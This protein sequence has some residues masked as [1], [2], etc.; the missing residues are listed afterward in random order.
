MTIYDIFSKSVEEGIAAD[1]RPMDE[2][3][4]YFWSEKISNGD[5]REL[6]NPYP[7]SGMIFVKETNKEVQRVLVGIDIGEGEI[8]GARMFEDETGKKIDLVISHHPHGKPLRNFHFILKTQLGNLKHCGVSV[9]GLER[10]YDRRMK[11]MEYDIMAVNFHRIRDT[12][13]I[14]G[15]DGISIHTPVDNLA[16]R[17]IQKTVSESGAKTLEDCLSALFCVPEYR[18]CR[19]ED[20]MS[21]TI[22]SGHKRGLLGRFLL[23]EFTGGEEGP[24]AVYRAM[25]RSGID[26]L[27]VMHMSYEALQEAKKNKMNVICCGH[28][29][30]D[31]ISMNLLC[32]I[33]EKEG[34]DVVS[35]GGFIRCRR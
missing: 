12:L 24:K 10:Q 23:T 5:G 6:V 3:L 8:L 20:S 25:K 21:P 26:T 9:A 33:L 1:F 29:N 34:I 28:I 31:S 32:D 19:D 27:F 30:S 13:S 22:I 16:A 7:D 4:N 14:L 35:T 15:M 17:L 2:V 18:R 11:D